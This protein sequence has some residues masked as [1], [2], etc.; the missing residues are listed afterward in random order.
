MAVI[1]KGLDAQVVGD[2][3]VF[4]VIGKPAES[5]GREGLWPRWASIN[6][7]TTCDI[8]AVVVLGPSTVN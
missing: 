6:D 7:C 2:V 8:V 3:R 5:V 1:R 4:S